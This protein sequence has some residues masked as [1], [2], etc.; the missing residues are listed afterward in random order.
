LHGQRIDLPAGEGSAIE[1]S[2]TDAL[3][4]VAH[5]FGGIEASGVLNQDVNAW[6]RAGAVYVDNALVEVAVKR[7]DEPAINPVRATVASMV[8]VV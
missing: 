3:A 4:F 2:G 8:L 5:V 6:R 7:A 1:H